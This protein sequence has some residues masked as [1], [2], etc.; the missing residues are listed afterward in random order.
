[1]T[2][3]HYK[4]HTFTSI[5]DFITWAKLNGVQVICERDRTVTIVNPTLP[6]L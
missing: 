4:G 2:Q 1:M 5:A 3:A 6:K